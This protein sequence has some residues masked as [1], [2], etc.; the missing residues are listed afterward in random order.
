MSKVSRDAATVVGTG[1]GAFAQ[2]LSAAS[3]AAQEA[4]QKD[5]RDKLIDLH[6]KTYS[7]AAAY[8]NAVM[9]G[10]YVAFF[11][12]W[13]SVQESL[14]PVCRLATAALMGISLVCYIGWQVIQML[15]RQWFEWKCADVFKSAGDPATFNT[16][17]SKASQNHEIATAR[18]MRFWPFLFVPALVFGFAGAIILSYNALAAVFGWPQLTG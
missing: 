8:D 13:G 15:T 9:L 7:T 4:H 14:T 11:A 6:S 17:W 3:A 18:L 2:A 1:K 16:E 12:L 10:G 5:V